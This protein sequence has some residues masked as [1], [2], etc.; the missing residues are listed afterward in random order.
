LQQA[1]MESLMPYYMD[2]HE[3]AGATAADVAAVHMQDLLIQDQYGVKYVNYWFD[4]EAQHA[5]CLAK[6]PTQEAVEAVHLASHGLV[7]TEVIEVDESAVRRFMGGIV[8]HPA[9]EPYVATAFRAILFT[10]LE[11]STGL[12]QQ[13]GDAGAM[14]VLRRHDAIVRA[15]LERTGGTEVK[16]TG[17][18]IMASFRSVVGAIEAAVSI[19]RGFAEAETAGDM[20]IGVRIG[21][22]AGE[23]VTDRDDL[24]GTAVQLAARLSSRAGGRT[25]LVA[26]VVRDLA[27]GKGFRFGVT[28]SIRLKGFDESVRACEVV[29]RPD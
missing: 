10:D 7:A 5:F 24:F 19:Q 18:G 17:D 22:A 2:R 1:L 28:R 6:G 20:P 9:G 25:I 23:P 12:T 3:L 13:L 21:L 16:H 27:S 15:A 8:E 26:G 4:Y 14:A 29:W 11:G